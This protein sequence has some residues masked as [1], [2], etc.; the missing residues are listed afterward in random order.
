M[1]AHGQPAMGKPG[2]PSEVSQLT[3]PNF[4]I[5]L[6]I[7]PP[8]PQLIAQKPGSGI[9]ISGAYVPAGQP[10]RFV[11]KKAHLSDADYRMWES[12]SGRLVAVS[13]HVGKNPYESLDPL[14]LSNEVNRH[15][16][17]IGEWESMC[18]VSGYCGMPTL[19]LRPKSMSMHGRQ[20]VQD[21]RGN[22]TYCNIGKESRLKS[23][24]VRHNLAV[25]R[26]KEK[27]VVY[28]ILVDLYG[29]TMQIVNT[30]DEL[31]A[32][33]QKS[34]TALVMNAAFGQGSE[35]FIDVAPGVDWSAILAIAVG[36]KQV[37]EHF[38][39]D[40]FSNFVS[41]P[42]QNAAVDQVVSAAGVQ[43][44]AT[45]AGQGIDHGVKIAKQAQQIFNM[46]YH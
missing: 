27:E 7:G 8:F 19:K 11:M 14:G 29:R 45:Q 1:A 2:K 18:Q 24:S 38:I 21:A 37:G 6:A 30:N 13:H 23:M 12:P 31:V 15:N 35:L 20:Y 22:Q 17:K 42:L 34:P 46:F 36:M 28:R 39:K 3:D 10:K 4:L 9:V 25:R 32:I 44:Q 41:A 5:E 40:A 33:I 16:S 43:A 26:G